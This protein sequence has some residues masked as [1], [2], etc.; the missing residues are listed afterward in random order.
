MLNSISWNYFFA[1]AAILVAAYYAALLIAFRFESFIW[2]KSKFSTQKKSSTQVVTGLIGNAIAETPGTIRK[3]SVTAEELIIN[4]G[5]QHPAE[6]LEI[7][8]ETIIGTI[9]DL[10]HESK[11]LALLLAD[12]KANREE[13]AALFKSLITR[14]PQLH[15]GY[16]EA[17]S[18]S[19]HHTCK[20]AGYEFSISEITAW[21]PKEITKS[22]YQ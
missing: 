7:N 9:A 21:W 19:L 3:Q 11:S 5:N 1:T 6:P 17:I 16:I 2:L 4:S 12:K 20:N 14:Y 22:I 13:F 10:L 8:R 15:A 18:I